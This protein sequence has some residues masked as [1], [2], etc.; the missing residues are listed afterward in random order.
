MDRRILM[1][2]FPWVASPLY[3]GDTTYVTS[4]AWEEIT[5][6]ALYTCSTISTIKLLWGLRFDSLLPCCNY[7]LSFVYYIF[8]HSLI[9]LF[10]Y[11]VYIMNWL[12]HLLGYL[13]IYLFV[14]SFIFVYHKPQVANFQAQRRFFKC[15]L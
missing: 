8:I 11:F 5:K 1:T 13:S 9:C 6:I 4:I 2:R 14:Y 10:V 15:L 3:L 7:G 12:I